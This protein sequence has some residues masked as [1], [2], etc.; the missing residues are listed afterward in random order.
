MKNNKYI[1]KQLSS[2]L[3]KKFGK[4]IKDV[5]LFGSQITEKTNKFSDYDIFLILK[6]DY[7][8]KYRKKINHTI[9]NLELEHD[10]LFDTHIISEDEIENTAKGIEP[11]Y[12]QAIKTGIYA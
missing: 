5:I 11:I 3:T 1:L 4:N 7:D 6:N 2:L 9:Y 12:L 8:W 10:I